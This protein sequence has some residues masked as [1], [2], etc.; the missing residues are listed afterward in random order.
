MKAHLFKL[1]LS[2]YRK[3][4]KKTALITFAIAWGAFSLLLLMS[5]GRGLANQFRVGLEGLGTDLVMFTSGQ[6]SKVYQGLAKGR[7]I[8]LYPDDI[9]LLR[10]RI[11][12]IKRI[13]AESYTTMQITYKDKDT[14]RTVNGVEP[15]FSVMRSTLANEGGRFIN[16]NDEAEARRVAFI[17]W[18]LAEYLFEGENPIGKDL[19]INR[20]PFKVV[21]VM[22]KKLQMGNYQGLAYDQI[23]I[24]FTT[25]QNLYSQ[26]FVDRIH[27][28]PVD[29]KYAVFL[30]RRAREVLG[31]KYRFD[32]EDEYALNV[33]NTI[34]QGEMTQKVFQGI[35]WFLSLIGALTLI[36]GA[37][38]VTNLMYAIVKERTREI[39]IKMALG[40]KRRHVVRQFL[41]E[42]LLIFSKGSLWGI[43]LAFNIVMLVRSVP[44]SYQMASI[45]SYLLR[46]IFSFDMVIMFL[47]VMASLVFFS[48]IF[49]ALK[50]SRLN[51][52]DALRYE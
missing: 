16:P 36:I 11:P 25:F 41:L 5:F 7:R 47:A 18:R 28:Q 39:G 2:E 50:A 51:P 4:K 24:P 32:S 31:E 29:R 52:V 10:S 38:G 37:V 48:G 22:K 30:E 19:S 17:G 42:A 33:W 40:A 43:L 13:I 27:V 46:P 45:Q 3:R 6:T 49:P 14:S 1:Y 15:E 26:K 9:D 23:Y 35:N 44:M 8:R 12:E 21:G 20:Q 34:T